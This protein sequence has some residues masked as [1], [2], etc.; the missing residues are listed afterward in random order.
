MSIC[1]SRACQ[2]ARAVDVDGC[3]HRHC[4]SRCKRTDGLEHNHWCLHQ[5]CMGPTSQFSN[6]PTARTNTSRSPPPRS[7]RHRTPSGCIHRCMVVSLGFL[8]EA[9]KELLLCNNRLFEYAIDVRSLQ[10]HRRGGPWGTHSQTQRRVSASR[11]FQPI[12]ER[13]LGRILT[14]PLVIIGCSAG[15]HRSVATAE[16]ADARIS[17]LHSQTIELEVI[18]VD[19][20]QCTAEQWRRLQNWHP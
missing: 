19:A 3:V 10:D 1:P 9:G 5:F 20:D 14:E 8:G 2:Y 12:L 15:H 18:H 4:C 17:E 16:I 13:V 7:D 6:H 11:G